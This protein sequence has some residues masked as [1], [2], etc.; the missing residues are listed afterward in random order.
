MMQSDNFLIIARVRCL[1]T[2][3]RLTDCLCPVASP[4]SGQGASVP[5]A[6]LPNGPHHAI[7]HAG[8]RGTQPLS[9]QDG[10]H[11]RYVV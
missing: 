1:A 5:A 10:R 11:H 6:V 7:R 8:L 2:C 3:I 9:L 4:Q